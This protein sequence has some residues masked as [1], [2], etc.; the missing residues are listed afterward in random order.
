MLSTAAVSCLFAPFRSRIRWQYSKAFMQKNVIK[1]VT[2][3]SEDQNVFQ[4][5]GRGEGIGQI[6]Q[7]EM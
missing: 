7:M 3:L 2:V 5:F 4:E 6:L 1:I